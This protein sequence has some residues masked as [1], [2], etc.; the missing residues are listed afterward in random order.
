MRLTMKF[1]GFDRAAERVR[2]LPRQVRFAGAQALNDAAFK[3]REDWRQEMA[4]V[5]DRPTPYVAGSPY[6]SRLARPEA[7]Q[8]WVQPRYP[9]GKSVDPASVLLAE[10]MGGTRRPKRFELAF[11]RAG[12]L[13]QNMA[14]VPAT[15]LL[16]DPAAGDGYG[17]IKGSFIVRLIS[18]LGAFS[19]GDQGYRANMTATGRAKLSGRGRW[20]NGKFYG[21]ATKTG[22]SN[23]G[24]AA[25]RRGG[26]EYFVSRGRGEFT[27]RGSW[28]NGQQQRLAAG[29]WQRSGLYGAD[30]KPVFLF[31]RMPRYRVRLD[32]AALRQRAISTHFPTRYRERLKRAL[33]TAR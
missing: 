25:V 11:R 31:T 32:L 23:K 14:M 3:A 4:R 27:G 13:P 18:Y 20:V 19:D 10:V 12:I 15:W 30:V 7:L 2:N 16:A 29:I 5:F 1:E 28:K 21:A 17:G 24:A 33:E 6:V 9:G 8:A 26:V 22:R